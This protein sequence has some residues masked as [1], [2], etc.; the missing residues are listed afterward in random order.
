MD[1]SD[2][3]LGILTDLW[4]RWGRSNH[5]SHSTVRADKNA[6]PVQR[7]CL[8]RESSEEQPLSERSGL[9]RKGQQDLEM[10]WLLTAVLIPR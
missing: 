2:R 3:H 6:H 10:L 8:F 5:Q 9:V 7:G 4:E 1:C